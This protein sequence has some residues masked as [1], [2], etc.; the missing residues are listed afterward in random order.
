MKKILSVM[1]VFILTFSL[2]ACGNANKSKEETNSTQVTEET[3]SAQAAG[4]TNS[5]QAAEGASSTQATE[6]SSQT[7]T[8]DTQSNQNEKSSEI[9]IKVTVGERVLTATLIDNATTR[10]LISKF[11]LNVPMMNLYS[12]EMC[13]R[14][15]DSLPANEQQE[16]GYEVGDL[17]YWSPRHSLVIFYSQNGEVIGNLQK[18]GHFDSNVEFFKDIPGDVNVKFELL[19]K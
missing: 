16:S 14:F 19:D 12:R 11:P 17:S 18:I 2:V 6:S 13:Y 10:S 1:F 5:I 7:S 4:E 15:A 8:P 3:D 9:K